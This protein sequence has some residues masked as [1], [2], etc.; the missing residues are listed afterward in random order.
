MPTIALGF[1]VTILLGFISLP[2]SS[3]R[4]VHRPRLLPQVRISW[5]EVSDQVKAASSGDPGLLWAVLCTEIQRVLSNNF[6]VICGPHQTDVTFQLANSYGTPTWKPRSCV[7]NGTGGQLCGDPALENVVLLET[8]NRQ[9][10]LSH[11]MVVILPFQP[12]PS[13]HPRVIWMPIT[14]RSFFMYFKSHFIHDLL[15][16]SSYPAEQA[17]QRKTRFAGLIG[18]FGFGSFSQLC[19]QLSLPRTVFSKAGTYFTMVSP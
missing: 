11:R 8:E 1:L 14:F 7:S 17:L 5:A 19:L 9:G 13:W 15:R 12:R 18:W 10:P 4:V 6:V 16:D 2:S 3:I